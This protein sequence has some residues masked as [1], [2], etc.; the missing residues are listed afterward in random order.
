MPRTPTLL[1]L[2][3]LITA[4]A[5]AQP[6]SSLAALEL[7]FISDRDGNQEL[8][9]A[10]R[11]GEVQSR[12]TNTPG[13]EFDP[14]WSPDG[15]LI[16]YVVNTPD[17]RWEVWTI[18]PDGSGAAKVTDLPDYSGEAALRPAGGLAPG[19]LAG[20]ALL[21][22][23]RP[24]GALDGTWQLYRV[25]LDGTGLEQLTSAGGNFGFQ[26]SPDGQ[27]I[28]FM[29][30]RDGNAEVYLMDS[31][32]TNQ[33]RLTFSPKLDSPASISSDS[34]LVAVSTFTSD[35]SR[36]TVS[37]YELSTG[38]L[39]QVSQNAESA[40][41]FPP[42]FIS[43]E[44][45]GFLRPENGSK[46]LIGRFGLGP[47]GEDP[48]PAP[49]PN[50][51]QASNL[52]FASGDVTP[53]SLDV[54]LPGDTPQLAI[55]VVQD[56]AGVSFLINQGNNFEAA[57]SPVAPVEGEAP[58]AAP[59]APEGSPAPETPEGPPASSGEAG[60]GIYSTPPSTTTPTAPPVITLP[61]AGGM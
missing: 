23:G 19:W 24:G 28:A 17:Q 42:S 27:I 1:A 18:A 22:Q 44:S 38:R 31:A 61:G 36:Q 20:S 52:R 39:L 4:T 59:P 32:G 30:D 51:E 10:S 58:G 37:I 33:R 2:G 54:V 11:D 34:R 40:T 55:L 9:A 60:E 26:V 3:L 45:Y 12:L 57:W 48:F 5:L 7:A 47:G 43:P 53:L 49:L 8:Y 14:S 21:I 13:S 6:L 25:N 29:S 50:L 46:T 16:A 35:F 56:T 15:R 41:F